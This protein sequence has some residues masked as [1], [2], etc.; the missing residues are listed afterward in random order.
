MAAVTPAAFPVSGTVLTAAEYNKLPR[1]VVFYNLVTANQTGIAST[2]VDLTNMTAATWTAVSGRTY[3]TTVYIPE[4]QQLTSGGTA[5]FRITDAS[6][7]NK[8]FGDMTAATNDFYSINMQVIETGLSGSVT[9]KARAS[10]T[11][12]TLSLLMAA[13]SPGFIMVEDIGAS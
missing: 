10:T 12:G 8:Q 2:V 1:G 13:T 3:R 4:I 7:V 9:R 11:A 6:N 5:V